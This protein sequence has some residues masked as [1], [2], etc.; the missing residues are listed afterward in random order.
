M[1]KQSGFTL[2][3]MI[4]AVAI[5]S[6]VLI[7][8]TNIYLIINNSQR[9]VVTLQKIQEDVRFLFD[10]I[11]QDIRLGSINYE[12]YQDEEIPLHPDRADR[13]DNTVLAM[14]DQDREQVYYRLNDTGDK[15][16][17]C[18][19]Q[20]CDLAVPADWDDITPDQVEILNLS[21]LVYPSADPFIDEPEV[22]CTNDNQ[23]DP[24]GYVCGTANTCVYFTDGQNFQPKVLFSI[25]SRGI[26][27]DLAEDS[28]LLMQS[29]ISTRIFPSEIKNLNYD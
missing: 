4:I 29:I 17:Y 10:A 15:I 18:S 7:A 13:L 1:K 19:G 3:E 22:D 27:S 8:A 11:S 14:I 12:F 5:F 24:S 9:K 23:C 28:E 25:K 6:L 21:F 16:Q 26:G 2:I 20:D